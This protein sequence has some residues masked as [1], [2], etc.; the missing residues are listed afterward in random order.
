[1]RTNV[2]L[3]LLFFAAASALCAVNFEEITFGFNGGYKAGTWAPLDVTVRSQNEAALFTGE[4][5]VEVRNRVSDVLIQQHTTSLQLSTT[6]WQRKRLYVYCPKTA[7]KFVVKLA[8]IGKPAQESA[9]RA[10]QEILP[11]AP[12]ENGDYFVLGLVPSGDKLQKLIDKKQLDDEGT[13]IHVKYLPNSDA[14]PTQWIGYSS[15]DALVIREIA[16]AQTRV[17]KSRQTALLDWIQRGGTL[18]VSGG[19]NFRYLKDSF[20][21]QFL[22]VQLIR[23]ETLDAVPPALQQQFGFKSEGDMSGH[24]RTPFKHIQFAP[25]PGC[26]TVIGT[27]EQIYVAKRFLGSGQILCLSFDYN[28]PPFSGR[29]A[30]A[31]FWSGLLK[32]HGKSPRL[33]AARYAQHRK[34]DEKIHEQFLSKM[35]TQVPLIK[36]LSLILPIY[37]LSFGGFLYYFGRGRRSSQKRVRG[38]WLGGAVLVFISISTIGVARTVLPKNLTADR[39]SILSIYPERARV[40]YQSYVSLRATAHTET[41]IAL[42]KNTFVRPLVSEKTA[43]GST[44]LPKLVQGSL[45]QVHAAYVEPWSPSTYLKEAFLDWQQPSIKLEDTWRFIGE[46]AIYYLGAVT[47]GESDLWTSGTS[48]KIEGKMPPAEGLNAARKPFAQILQREGVLQ[49]LT[50]EIKNYA[51]TTD[52]SK[53]AV[54]IGWMSQPKQFTKAIPLTT[55]DGNVTLN[56]ETLVILYLQVEK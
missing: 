34:H 10:M 55:A 31:S 47:L 14:M 54:C 28:A 26:H 42:T 29:H 4:L 18:I 16:L 7:A 6:D 35:P 21:E 40:H 30:A 41:S 11:P 22:P 3:F 56:D 27:N 15:V 25:H 39:F 53:R 48:G 45:F 46:E 5:T 8:R 13:Q 50:T 38:Y 17:S 1:M 33:L 9:P 20:I 23:E 19:S 2:T 32:T 24:V 37:L 36:L 51:A 49:Y 12:I 44:T 52:V 43:G